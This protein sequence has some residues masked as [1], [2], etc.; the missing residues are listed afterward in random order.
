MGPAQRDL[1]GN[2][3]KKAQ[4]KLPYEL[5]LLAAAALAWTVILYFL[6]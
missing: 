4:K 5:K 3:V 1:Q 6:G 2:A